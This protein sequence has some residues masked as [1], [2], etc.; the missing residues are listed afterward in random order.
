MEGKIIISQPN[1]QEIKFEY[2][3]N[4][5]KY[6]NLNSIN[7]FN[8]DIVKFFPEENK[9]QTIE[10][11]VR[12]GK[13][14]AG[15]LI[16]ESNT[17]YGLNKK[18]R[19]Y[20]LF[21]PL[22]WKLPN[23]LVSSSH[24]KRENL[25]VEIKF[26]KWEK[27]LPHG[28][29]EKIF[30]PEKILENRYQALLS[31]YG[32]NTKNINNLFNLDEINYD[33]INRIDLFDLNI[34]TIDPINCKD[35]D[36][37]V[38]YKK[39]SNNL[40]QIGVHITD[41]TSYIPINSTIDLEAQKR[42]TSVYSPNKTINMIPESL[43]ENISSLYKGETKKCI[44]VIFDF[45]NQG[46]LIKY[47]IIPTHIMVKQNLS[48]DQFDTFINE[49]TNIN[50]SDLFN[51]TKKIKFGNFDFN[52]Y[53]SHKM[54]EK[55]MILTNHTVCQDLINQGLN[56]VI[57]RTHQE[58]FNT[59]LDKIPTEIYNDI[60]FKFMNSAE[61]QIYNSESTNYHS[62]LNMYNYTHFT[63]PI[64]RYADMLIHRLIKSRWDNQQFVFDKKIVNEIN[65]KNKIIK[66]LDREFK[67]Y[68]ILDKIPEL[69]TLDGYITDFNSDTK[70]TVFI[71]EFKVE[72]KTIIIHH[73]IR[74]LFEISKADN[75][76]IIL[77]GDK[78]IK[79]KKYM[80]IKIKLF[81]KKENK[82]KIDVNVLEPDVKNFIL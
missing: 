79:F 80:K 1:Y 50:M 59:E 60:F 13:K 52:N 44:S 27:K 62:G 20:Y 42:L 5:I 28:M 69:D 58:S 63:S 11:K 49:N 29:I 36:D 57:I 25:F 56:N 21:K 37:A 43:S 16:L 22:D 45:D 65:Q 70:V 14:I 74:S 15:L 18:G 68:Q 33:K 12:N 6:L 48:Y 75:D 61:Y 38:H 64:R 39:I 30:G 73:K 3:E 40:I 54:I 71:P 53:D 72:L 31:N 4:N 47:Q 32:V 66:K 26:N 35:M 55:L 8:N 7:F 24:K 76:L 23:F 19:P 82:Y 67:I 46:N 9:I 41:V 78:T 2:N 17:K 34:I 51:F 10:S 81:D 77:K